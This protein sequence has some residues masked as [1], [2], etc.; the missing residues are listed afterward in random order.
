MKEDVCEDIP[1][2]INENATKSINIVGVS[3]RYQ[4][5]KL[6]NKDDINK[7]KMRKEPQKWQLPEEVYDRK[8]QLNV[9]HSINDDYT[10]DNEDNKQVHKLIKQQLE[11]KLNNY[12]QQDIIKHIY[13]SANLI[14]INDVISKLKESELLCYYCK[15]ELLIL[16]EI[17]RESFQWT[18]DRVDNSLGHNTNNVIIACLHCN[19]KRRK[20]NKEAFLFTKQLKIVKS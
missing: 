7:K 11:R 14:N 15:N 19:L 3:N 17:V 8:Y 12:K 5:K 2:I 18:L 13:D 20:Q 4:I 10:N 9:L 1:E 16:Y 6:T